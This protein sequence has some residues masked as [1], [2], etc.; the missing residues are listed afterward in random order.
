MRKQTTAKNNKIMPMK[1]NNTKSIQLKW[2][3]SK[4]YVE[5]ECEETEASDGAFK[6]FG[7]GGTQYSPPLIIWNGAVFQDLNESPW[8]YWIAGAYWID[9]RHYATRREEEKKKRTSIMDSQHDEN[10]T[11][12]KPEQESRLSNDNKF[13][14][15]WTLPTSYAKT[16]KERRKKTRNRTR[17]KKMRMRMRW[18]KPKRK[19]QGLK[20]FLHSRSTSPEREKKMS[21]RQTTDKTKHTQNVEPQV[22]ALHQP[23]TKQQCWSHASFS[24]LLGVSL[25]SLLLRKATRNQTDPGSWYC[26]RKWKTTRDARGNTDLRCLIL[27]RITVSR[28]ND[29]VRGLRHRLSPAQF[30]GCVVNQR[31]W[32]QKVQAN[33]GSKSRKRCK[34]VI[35]SMAFSASSR[36]MKE[37]NPIQLRTIKTQQT[38]QKKRSHRNTKMHADTQQKTQNTS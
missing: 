35:S 26:K 32:R 29:R 28:N 1:T 31:A 6:S 17:R 37:T 22:L 24:Y 20:N 13:A 38:T 23:H 30:A 15:V 9:R 36:S 10:K 7:F 11:E 2:N 18:Q 19:A 27:P 3:E 12:R 8:V 21:H 33:I 34:P 25:Q 5:E 14:L 4:A 16:K